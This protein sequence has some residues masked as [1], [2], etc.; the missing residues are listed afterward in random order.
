LPSG[1]AAGKQQEQ[2]MNKQAAESL[3]EQIFLTAQALQFGSSRCLGRLLTS[4][5]ALKQI[6]RK[7]FNANC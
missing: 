3:L 4:P 2:L 6:Q 7:T 1:Q 5:A